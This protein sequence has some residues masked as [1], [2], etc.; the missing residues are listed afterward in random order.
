[1]ALL[2]SEDSLGLHAERLYRQ[3]GAL[4]KEGLP[5]VEGETGGDMELIGQ[6]TGKAD[7]PDDAVVDPGDC[8]A[9]DIEIREGLGIEVNPGGEPFQEGPRLGPGHVDA[10]KTTRDRSD[11]NLPLRVRGLEPFLEHLPDGASA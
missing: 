3:V 11:M 8:P 4:L 1:M 5:D 7:P 9:T 10:G 6:L 2:E